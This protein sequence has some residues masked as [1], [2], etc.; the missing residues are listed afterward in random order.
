LLTP[1][2]YLGYVLA[3]NLVDGDNRHNSLG[4]RGEEIAVPKPDGE[5]RIVCLGASTT[6]SLLVADYRRSYPSLLEKT[7][8]SRGYENV[9]V[10]NAG[11]P[12][13]STY[14]ILINYL[15][16]I[17]SLEPDLIIMRE[18]FAD[19]ACRMVWPPSA[20]KGDNSGCLA[21]RFV[22]RETPVYES[23]TLIRIL[24]V[25]TGLA[26]PVSALGKSVYNQ[27]D[28]SYFFE[29]AKQRFSMNYPTGI[30]ETVSVAQMLAANPPTSYRRNLEDLMFQ[31]KARGVGR[32]L[33]TFPYSPEIKG[34]FGVD[35]FRKGL[36]GHNAII[37]DVASKMDVPL[38]DLARSVPT[39][40]EYW[41][42]DGIHANEAGVEL[43]AKIAAD[44]HI[45][46]GL[47]A[48]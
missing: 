23:S 5:F 3:P 46:R 43:H 29:F 4:F 42:F 39:A 37:R 48:R 31:A 9:K 1:H 6:Y 41:G 38:L 19:L 36:D 13:W 24:L 11:V 21:A 25:Q 2:R 27:A 12:A 30:F 16:R 33:T 10:V 34:Y 18:A 14:E 47:I 8:R 45:E 15:L 32:V 28:T 20:F 26:L 40:P 17:Q 44:F 35:G 7:L 22:E